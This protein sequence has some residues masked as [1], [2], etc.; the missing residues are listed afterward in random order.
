MVRESIGR[1]HRV[2]KRVFQRSP[3]IKIVGLNI[4]LSGTEV[5]TLHFSFKFGGCTYIDAL[6]LQCALM[7]TLT[8]Y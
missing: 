1:I 7:Q 6:Q 4:A 3:I 8:I 5:L 2:S